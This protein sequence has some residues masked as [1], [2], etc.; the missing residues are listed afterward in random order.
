MIIILASR[1]ITGCLAQII[2]FQTE[3]EIQQF[4]RWWVNDASGFKFQAWA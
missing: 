2:F 1:G 3:Y 4:H